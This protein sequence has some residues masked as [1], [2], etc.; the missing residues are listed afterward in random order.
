LLS[1]LNLG[2]IFFSL[3]KLIKKLYNSEKME[4]TNQNIQ[5]AQASD[6]QT[7]VRK[8]ESKTFSTIVVMLFLAIAGG[9]GF[10]YF[11]NYNGE[12][13]VATLKDQIDKKETGIRNIL[14]NSQAGQ[15][16][17]ARSILNNAE[18]LRIKWSELAAGVLK[19]EAMDASFMQFSIGKNREVSVTGKAKSYE[20]VVRLLEKLKKSP[21][22][23]NA[24]ISTI[25]Y[26][27][28]TEKSKLGIAASDASFQLIFDY[29]ETPAEELTS[30]QTPEK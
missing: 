6:G 15:H 4:N 14:E 8:K 12:K 30:E 1:P 10:L 28:G 5:V 26:S 9:T 19:Q 16:F 24:F 20:A 27:S 13:D 22:V 17:Q 3:H 7:I 23:E 25:S 18:K 21:N 29:V 2:E 11:Q